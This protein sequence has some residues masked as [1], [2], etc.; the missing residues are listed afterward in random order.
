MPPSAESIA[1][2]ARSFTGQLITPADPEYDERR[3]V[4]NGLIDKRPAFIAACR[5]VADIVDAV[6]LARTFGLDVSVRGG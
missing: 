6:H 3:R 4:H 2:T 5:G 1:S